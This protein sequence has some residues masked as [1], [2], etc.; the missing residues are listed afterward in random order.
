MTTFKIN[1][2]LQLWNQIIGKHSDAN[3]ITTGLSNNN[4]NNGRSSKSNPNSK[5]SST[6]A[7]RSNVQHVHHHLTD[8]PLDLSDEFDNDG[9]YNDGAFEIS[10]SDSS[11]NNNNNNFNEKRAS[12]NSDPQNSHTI[13]SE[14]SAPDNM[15]TRFIERFD[16]GSYSGND[17]S[18]NNDNNSYDVYYSDEDDEG[19]NSNRVL[20]VTNY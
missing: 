2:L 1:P 13:F 15:Y 8:S 7:D 11:D 14:D 18:S 4:N 16:S 20:N 12:S 9:E 5:R 3:I 10:L 6:I 17:N 19:Y